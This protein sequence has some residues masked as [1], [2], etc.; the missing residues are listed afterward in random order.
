MIGE[1]IEVTSIK[2]GKNAFEVIQDIGGPEEISVRRLEIV[3]LVNG[4]IPDHL[5]WEEFLYGVKYDWHPY[6]R[7][8]GDVRD[9]AKEMNALLGLKHARC[10]LKAQRDIPKEWLKYL[11]LFPGATL[12]STRD[13]ELHL[14]VLWGI[15]GEP[16]LLFLP[17]IRQEWDLRRCR[18]LRWRS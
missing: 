16:S 12:R 10:L 3:P 5:T 7:T 8:Y 18:F 1:I 13:G 11:I 4:K 9:R 15:C 2:K 14:P 17:L 6:D